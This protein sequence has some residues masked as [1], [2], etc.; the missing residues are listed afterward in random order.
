MK[1]HDLPRLNEAAVWALTEAAVALATEVRREMATGTLGRLG[2]HA[3]GPG[4]GVNGARRPRG[5]Y[6]DPTATAA[7]NGSGD[8][9]LEQ[10]AELERLMVRAVASLRLVRE[11]CARNP[12]PAPADRAGVGLS[13]SVGASCESCAR[14]P[15]P[16]PRGRRWEPPDS[17]LVGATDVGGRLE[18]RRYLCVWC[19]EKVRAWGRLPSPDELE[20]HHAGRR[21]AWPADVPAPERRKRSPL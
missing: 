17:R 13:P 16:G 3:A 19:H 2:E 7:L 8:P 1:R 11:L 12:V 21:V 20:A 4:P 6:S 9:A 10:R 15:G 5:A 18:S 14:L